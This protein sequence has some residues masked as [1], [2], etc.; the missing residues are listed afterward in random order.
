[1]NTPRTHKALTAMACRELDRWARVYAERDQLVR[2]AAQSGVGV[3]EIARRMGIAKTTVIRI[4]APRPSTPASSPSTPPPPPVVD[5]PAAP[6]LV[7]VKGTGKA[8]HADAALADSGRL[9]VD[10]VVAEPE[11]CGCPKRDGMVYH[12]RATCTDPIAARLDWYA[13]ADPAAA[14]AVLD[15]AAAAVDGPLVVIGCGA[16]KLDHPAPAAELYTGTY[17]R[18]CLATARAIA[19]PESIR[20]LSAKHGLVRLDDVL[21]PYDV[22]LGDPFDRIP[23]RAVTAQAIDQGLAGRRVLALCSARYADVLRAAGFK[24]DAPLANLG[25]GRQ[26]RKLAEMRRA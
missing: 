21:E 11:P 16:G 20:I 5:E 9:V 2:S 8:A 12:Q 17:F 24:V 1:M 10:P 7:G 4:L 19:D 15:E 3:N 18:E 6:E 26:R 25:I 13:D 14:A 22:T 23:T